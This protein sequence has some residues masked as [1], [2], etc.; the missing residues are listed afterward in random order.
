MRLKEEVSASITY[1]SFSLEEFAREILTLIEVLNELKEYQSS[2][3][4][5]WRWLAIWSRKGISFT[6]NSKVERQRQPS[7]YKM[8]VSHKEKPKKPKTKRGALKH[9]LWKFL[10][11]LRRPE[12]K[13]SVKV[14]VGSI[15]L[16]LPAFT[17][18]YSYIYSH[19]RGEWAL[20][21]Y[22]VIIANSVGATTS[23][24]LWRYIRLRRLL[25]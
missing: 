23:V 15:L 24:G 11:K 25:M 10:E 5:E 20:L 22:F 6:H 19:W 16:A 13:F 21:S 4:R 7:M 2:E 3:S 14:G 12:I 1:F 17:Q 9:R 18:R 8:P